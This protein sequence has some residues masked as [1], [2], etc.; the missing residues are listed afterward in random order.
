MVK[1]LHTNMYFVQNSG[2]HKGK[3]FHLLKM[4]IGLPLPGLKLCYDLNFYI[5]SYFTF[6]LAV[7]TPIHKLGKTE[8]IFEKKK[9]SLVKKHNFIF[10]LNIL[11]TF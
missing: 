1:G 4:N 9:K 7:W 5:S 8:T 11:K 3:I 6:I 2:F 10:S